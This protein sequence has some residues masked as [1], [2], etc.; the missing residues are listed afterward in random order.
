[1]S[2][3]TTLASQGEECGVGPA[4]VV[5]VEEIL[6]ERVMDEEAAQFVEDAERR[7]VAA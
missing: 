3:S 5:V 6:V 2:R 4:G 7:C 1:M